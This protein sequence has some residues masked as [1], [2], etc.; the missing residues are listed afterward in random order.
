M[1]VQLRP[2]SH[3]AST[4]QSLKWHA[5]VFDDIDQQTALQWQTSD[6]YAYGYNN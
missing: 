1:E 3:A 2:L 5:R 6:I 4:D